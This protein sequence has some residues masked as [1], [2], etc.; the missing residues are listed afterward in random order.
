MADT[1]SGATAGAAIGSVIPGV[2]TAIGAAL[3][4]ILGGVAGKLFSS[5]DQDKANA[6]QQK[7]I[8]I[9]NAVGAPPDLQKQIILDQYKSAGLYSPQLE[10]AVADSVSQVAKIQEDPSLRSAQTQALQSLQQQGRVGL[11][12]TDRAALNQERLQNASDTEGKRQQIIQN[13]QQRGQAGSGSELAAQLQAAQ[14]GSDQASAAG[15]RIA[16]QASQNALSAIG[17]AGTLGGQIRSQDFSNNAAKASAADEMNRFNVQ[18]TINRN[19]R[20]TAAT[21]QAQQYNVQNAQQLANANTAQANQEQQREAQA[22]Q[23]QWQDQITQAQLQAN[24]QNQ[25]AATYSG[26]AA[27]AAQSG[28]NIGSGVGS[29]FGALGNYLNSKSTTPKVPSVGS[30][31]DT[32][33]NVGEPNSTADSDN[34]TDEMGNI[35][36]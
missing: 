1:A 15:D 17:Q 10:S 8:D 13:M 36:S 26:K 25:A 28:V 5:G 16:A 27:Q 11:S 32:T 12:A 18:N 31:G 35:I 2:G 7:A 30:S 4:G 9:I 34:K 19:V 22:A 24:A 14:G 6:A 33:L 23:Q 3:G 20:N 29:A 21:N